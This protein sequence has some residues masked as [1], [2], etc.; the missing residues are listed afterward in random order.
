MSSTF[1]RFAAIV[2]S[3]LGVEANKVT[4]DASFID[5]LGADSLDVVELMMAAEEEFNVEISDDDAYDADTV[6]KFAAL[7]DRR[8]SEKTRGA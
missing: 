3:H 4:E 2:T 1:E 6:G 5:D 8:L 7:I